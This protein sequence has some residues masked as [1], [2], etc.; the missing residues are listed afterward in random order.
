MSVSLSY[1][2]QTPVSES[3]RES[4]LTAAQQSNAE[5][6]WWCESINFFDAPSSAGRLQGDTKLFLTGYSTND[7]DFIEVDP[8]DD[9]IMAWRDAQHILGK[10]SEWSRQ[11][12]ITWELESAGG[13]LGS[14]RNGAIPDAAL[15]VL[16]DLMEVVGVSP[17]SPDIEDRAQVIL[18]QHAGR[19]S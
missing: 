13:S 10:L 12:S 11:H 18:R 6:D 5:R 7:G 1:S 16:S 8:E 19:N 3:V 4:I 14:V 15:A 9:C 2:T 17:D